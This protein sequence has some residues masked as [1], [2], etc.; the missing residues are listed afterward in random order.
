[1]K[2]DIIVGNLIAE[3]NKLKDAALAVGGRT[4]SIRWALDGKL[5]TSYG[6]V[7]RRRLK[8]Q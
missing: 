3:Y 7:W 1:M 8:E 6:Y 2:F 5:K 4:D